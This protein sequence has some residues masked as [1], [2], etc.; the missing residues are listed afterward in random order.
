MNI[1]KHFVI[2]LWIAIIILLLNSC[3]SLRPR[4]KTECGTSGIYWSSKLSKIKVKIASN[5]R[6][7]PLMFDGEVASIINAIDMWN[8]SFDMFEVCLEPD[9]K[10]NVLIR[11]GG[12]EFKESEQAVN[13]NI[14]DG[15]II[16]S[17]TIYI[18]KNYVS[19]YGVDL[20]SLLLHELGHTLG[21]GHVNGTIMNPTMSSVTIYNSIDHELKNQVSCLYNLNRTFIHEKEL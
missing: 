8:E 19:K 9:C 16:R 21:L 15:P 20:K 11:Y 14:L 6:D 5:E 2:I 7:M 18:N 13:R 17:A 4:Y 3:A 1:I 12:I 10:Y